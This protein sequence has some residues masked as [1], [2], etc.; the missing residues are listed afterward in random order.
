VVG[1]TNVWVV[2][3]LV[4]RRRENERVSRG[5][6]PRGQVGRKEAA[7][8]VGVKAKQS[9]AKQEKRWLC[10]GVMLAVSAER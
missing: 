6:D 3:A 2:A 1:C 9:K 5:H 7:A 10:L 8:A 4:A